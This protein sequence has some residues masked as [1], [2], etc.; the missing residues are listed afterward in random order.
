MCCLMAHNPGALRST[1]PGKY[2]GLSP[3]LSQ[4]SNM[5]PGP[6]AGVT[7]FLMKPLCLSLLL[8]AIKK[9]QFQKNTTQGHLCGESLTSAAR[10]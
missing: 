2:S 5:L 6:S 9:L 10:R 7:Q 4:L 8:L 3:L 1:V